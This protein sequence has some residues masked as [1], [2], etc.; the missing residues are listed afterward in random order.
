M[1][2]DDELCI[3]CGECIPYCPLGAIEMGDTA[4][5]NQDECVECGICIRQIECPVDAFYEPPETMKWPRSVR[6]VFSDPTAKHENTGVRGRGTEEV[7][8]NDVTA[9]FKRGYLGMALE[10]GRPG[11]GTRLGDVEIITTTLAQAGIEFEPNNPLTHLMED[12]HAGS[13]KE[14]VRNEKVSSAIVEFVIPEG[15]LEDCVDKITEAASRAQC[16]FS[17]GIVARF[18]PDGSLPVVERLAKLGINVPKNM[19]VNVGLGR[20]RGEDKT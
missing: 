2:I 14:D 16:I 17:W 7:K 4:Q 5:I 18:E 10:F 19:K 6:K 11:V 9:R 1:K 12:V 20:P 3:S 15:Q 13:I 8:T